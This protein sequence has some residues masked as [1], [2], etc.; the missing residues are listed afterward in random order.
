MKAERLKFCLHQV[1]IPLCTKLFPL[2]LHSSLSQKVF[3][4]L[5]QANFFCQYLRSS[6]SHSQ[7]CSLNCPAHRYL[8]CGAHWHPHSTCS[9]RIS[10]WLCS[11]ESLP[12]ELVL[13]IM[14]TFFCLILVAMQATGLPGA[15][16][17]PLHWF[18]LTRFGSL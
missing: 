15:P 2:Q 16:Q 12:D 1:S 4:S 7:V 18:S 17:N 11:F 9:S 14:L 13:N 8:A 6:Q 5:S 3:G 10:S